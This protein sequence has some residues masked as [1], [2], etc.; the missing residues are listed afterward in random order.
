MALSVVSIESQVIDGKDYWRDAPAD[1][2][3]PQ[4]DGW[5]IFLATVS[6]YSPYYAWVGCEPCHQTGRMNV[7][8][9][10]VTAQLVEWMDE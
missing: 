5:G 7:Y 8:T 1:D 6:L 9:E 2:P 10:T 4:C 3:C